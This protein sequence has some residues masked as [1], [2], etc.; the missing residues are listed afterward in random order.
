MANDS[1]RPKETNWKM[2]ITVITFLALA[3]TAYALR[4]Q[5]VETLKNL[6]Q[7]NPWPILLLLPLAISNH[8]CQGKLY[9]R[10]FRILG[11]NYRIK[12]MFRL[13]L[14]MNFVNNVFPSGGVSGF[15]YLSIRMKGE[16][17]TTGKS[18]LV[19]IMRFALLFVSFQILLGLGLLMLAFSGD[20]S[21]FVMLVAGSL[22]TL[23]FVGTALVLYLIS[24]KQRMNAFFTG[25]TRGLNRL[26]HVIR[27]KHPETI[28]ITRVERVFTELHENYQLLKRNIRQLKQPLGYA[29][30]ANILEITAI[31]SVFA[32]FGYLIN[33]GAII[34][35]YAVANFAGIVSILPGGIG[36][37]EGLMTGV[38]AAAGVP[39]GISLPVVIAFRV[40]S[41]G[42]QLPPGYYFYQKNLHDNK[43]FEQAI[44]KLQENNS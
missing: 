19:Q 21:N 2:I 25:F 35:A 41:M 44:A 33:P 26:I 5:I 4:E 15:S 32:A 10:M 43:K 29:L 14:E 31:F 3:I 9:Q 24:N 27:P 17:T 20:A 23:L 37:Y 1:D 13:S 30:M 38:F 34:I 11:E 42:I 22:A 7:A 6:S 16:G 39:P 12:S 18:T 36:I 28:S 8:I 40:V